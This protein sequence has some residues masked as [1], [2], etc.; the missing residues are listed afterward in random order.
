MLQVQLSSRGSLRGVCIIDGS[1]HEPYEWGKPPKYTS[2]LST[3][4]KKPKARFMPNSTALTPANH[5]LPPTCPN[6]ENGKSKPR[7]PR[8]KTRTLGRAARPVPEL[9]EGR[10]G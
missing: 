4:D 7:M 9:T 5:V 3:H 8:A 10:R 2:H 6:L 1:D